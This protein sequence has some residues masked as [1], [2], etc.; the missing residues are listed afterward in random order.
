MNQ[1]KVSGKHSIESIQDLIDQIIDINRHVAEW[2]PVTGQMIVSTPK[3]LMFTLNTT[4]CYSNDI[5]QWWNMLPVLQYLQQS[6]V[7]I[8]CNVTGVC[9][10]AFVLLL[11]MSTPGKRSMSRYGRIEI[12]PISAWGGRWR[13]RQSQRD[14]DHNHAKLEELVT[15]KLKRCTKL[16]DQEIRRIFY[17][18]VSYD[19]PT[20]RRYGLIDTISRTGRPRGN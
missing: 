5:F 13:N 17:E 3:H 7:P 20:A 8:C 14:A 15:R 10:N 18:E 1:Y 4:A 11:A 9:R 19:A 2:S 6:R 12:Q 16:P